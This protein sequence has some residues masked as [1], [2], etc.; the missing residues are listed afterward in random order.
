MSEIVR[1][2]RL[3]EKGLDL[4][5]N[6]LAALPYRDVAVLIA[7]MQTQ[8]QAQVPKPPKGKR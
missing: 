4:V 8:L 2:L 7:D 6:A 3:N 5:V 1:T